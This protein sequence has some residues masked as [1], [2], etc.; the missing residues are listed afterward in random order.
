MPAWAGRSQ[1]V[2]EDTLG[3]ELAHISMN[4]RVDSLNRLIAQSRLQVSPIG[5][6]AKAWDGM[7]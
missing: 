6:K 7:K 1:G 4:A 2:S 3:V 5:A